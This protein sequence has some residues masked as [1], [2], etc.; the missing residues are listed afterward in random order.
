[1]IHVQRVRR[2]DTLGT[3]RGGAE[4]YVGHKLFAAVALHKIVWELV[5]QVPLELQ[6][7]AHPEAVVEVRAACH[8][9]GYAG[10]QVRVSIPT[11]TAHDRRF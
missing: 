8:P 7:G 3:T 9:Y 6:K 2:R 10:S 5:V 11:T 4:T 1:M